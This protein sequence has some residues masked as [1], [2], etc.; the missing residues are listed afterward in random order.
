MVW[1]PATVYSILACPRV[2]LID[3]QETIVLRDDSCISSDH[4]VAFDPTDLG[5][6]ILNE[7]Q[8]AGV[9]NCRKN[10][11]L[12]IQSKTMEPLPLSSE[13]IST[14]IPLDDDSDTHL[15]V[16]PPATPLCETQNSASPSKTLDAEGAEVSKPS[17]P[18]DDDSDDNRSLTDMLE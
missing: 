6:P 16:T 15:P 13:P 8:R 4:D 9:E 14:V 3:I 5:C 12:S 2:T 10:M 1:F 18:Q 7:E 17:N 11:E